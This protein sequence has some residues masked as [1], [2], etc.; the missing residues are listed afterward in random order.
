MTYWDCLA[1]DFELSEGERCADAII[2]F[3]RGHCHSFALALHALCIEAGIPAEIVGEDWSPHWDTDADT[4]DHVAV[5]VLE[6]G[7]VYDVRGDCTEPLKAA[8]VC[9]WKSCELDA[10]GKPSPTYLEPEAERAEPWARDV[11]AAEIQRAKV[12]A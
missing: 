7:R 8:D 10:D 12:A 5:R 2:V 1:G 11:F 3:T 4:P 6:T 9:D